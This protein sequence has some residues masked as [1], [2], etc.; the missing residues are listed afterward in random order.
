MLEFRNFFLASEFGK[1]SSF[2]VRDYLTWVNFINCTV[3]KG[4]TLGQAY[5]HGAFV[6]FLDTLGT[7]VTS[8][9]V[10]ECH[11]FR[12]KCFKFLRA[13]MIGVKLVTKAEFR[14]TPEIERSGGRFGT[15]GFSIESKSVSE[16]AD[17][18]GN[19]LFSFKTP[20]THSNLIKILRAMQL[21]KA[22]LLEGSPGVGKTAL[23]QALAQATG[24]SLTRINLSEQTDVC[25]LFGTDLPVDGGDGGTFE[26]KDGP[27]LK[28]LKD[29]HWILLDELNLASQSVLEGLN[30]VLDHRGELFIPEIGRSFLVKPGTRLFATQNPLSQ[31]S[32]RKGLPKSFLNRFTQVYISSFTS[33]DIKLIL[34]HIFQDLVIGNKTFATKIFDK[35]LLFNERL[36]AKCGVEFG[37][38]GSPWEMNLRDLVR[39]VEAM[40]RFNSNN[41]GDF[42]GVIYVDRMRTSEDKRQ[43]EALYKE[44]FPEK[45]FA[46][47]KGPFTLYPTSEEIYFGDIRLPKASSGVNLECESALNLVLRSDFNALRSLAVTT[48][49]QWM[50]ILVG[51]EH[52]KHLINTFAQLSGRKLHIVS[53]SSD[54]DTMEIL[55]GY[56]QIDLNRHLSEIGSQV[57][58]LLLHVL[59][60]QGGDNR[61]DTMQLVEQYNALSNQVVPLEERKDTKVFLDKIDRLS[62]L[63]IP[64]SSS[65]IAEDLLSQLNSF[66]SRVLALSQSG[67]IGSGG[68]EWVDSVLVKALRQGSWLLMDN[69]NM[70]SAAVL[71]RLNGLLEPSGVLTLHERGVSSSGELYTIVPHP[72]F[73]LFLCMDP[74]YG[75][76]SRAMR[77][78]GVEIALP[79]EQSS[80]LSAS[81]S[82]MGSNLDL[83]EL[84]AVQGVPQFD[85][86]CLLAHIHVT[87]SD[88]CVLSNE[89]SYLIRAA[90]LF[91][92]YR[93]QKFTVKAALHIACREIYVK[94]HMWCP[95]QYKILGDLLTSILDKEIMGDVHRVTHSNQPPSIT[96]TNEQAVS[97]LS[98]VMNQT[99]ELVSSVASVDICPVLPILSRDYLY[100]STFTRIRHQSWLLY[101]YVNAYMRHNCA[102][103]IVTRSLLPIPCEELYEGIL[104]DELTFEEAFPYLVM[105]AYEYASVGDMAFRRQ[106][107]LRIVEEIKCFSA[108]QRRE[109]AKRISNSLDNWDTRLDETCNNNVRISPGPLS[110]KKKKSKRRTSAYCDSSVVGNNNLPQSK[111]IC[112]ISEAFDRVNCDSTVCDP[113]DC[114]RLD[115]LSDRLRVIVDTV[116]NVAEGQ[117]EF[118]LQGEI[119]RPIDV[120]RTELIPNTNEGVLNKAM[121]LKM[122]FTNKYVAACQSSVA[123]SNRVQ[124]KPFTVAAYSELFEKDDLPFTLDSPILSHF[125]TIRARMDQLV[126]SIL[127]TPSSQFTGQDLVPVYLALILRDRFESIGSER[128]GPEQS[129]NHIEQVLAT[130]HLHFQ[131]FNKLFH[132]MTERFYW[133]DGSPE[134]KLH[135]SRLV[136]FGKFSSTLLR[137]HNR[138]YQKHLVLA[139]KKFHTLLPMPLPPG[140]NSVARLSAI[141]RRAWDLVDVWNHGLTE[142]EIAS[143]ITLLTSEPGRQLKAELLASLSLLTQDHPPSDV[144]TDTISNKIENLLRR[145]AQLKDSSTTAEESSMQVDC[146]SSDGKTDGVECPKDVPAEIVLENG[147]VEAETASNF[148]SRTKLVPFY[149]YLALR[150]NENVTSFARKEI[151]LNRRTHVP[152][153]GFEDLRLLSVLLR[154]SPATPPFVIESLRGGAYMQLLTGL[155]EMKLYNAALFRPQAW[156]HGE[157]IVKEDEEEDVEMMDVTASAAAEKMKEK[158][159]DLILSPE[160][161]LLSHLLTTVLLKPHTH[162]FTHSSLGS[163]SERSDLL[164]RIKAI[165]WRNMPTIARL[166]NAAQS[167]LLAGLKSQYEALVGFLSQLVSGV[168]QPQILT[169]HLGL[170]RDYLY[171]SSPSERNEARGEIQLLLGH[172]Q[173]VILSKMELID[174]VEKN[175]LKLR[176]VRHVIRDIQRIV[177]LECQHA[178][179][180]GSGTRFP[181]AEVYVRT[182]ST[183]EDKEDTCMKRVGVRPEQSALMYSNLLKE[184]NSFCRSVSS[185][186]RIRDIIRCRKLC[187]LHAKQ[188]SAGHFKAEM[189][190]TTSDVKAELTLWQYSVMSFLGKLRT[191]YGAWYP[192]VVVP[193]AYAITQMVTGVNTILVELQRNLCRVQLDIPSSP[194]LGLLVRFP[195]VDKAE[196][197]EFIGVV[198]SATFVKSFEQCFDH[199]SER[200]DAVMRLVKCSLEELQNIIAI[201]NTGTNGSGWCQLKGRTWDTMKTILGQLVTSWHSKTER[202]TAAKIEEESLYLHKTR[203]LCP[204]EQ[205]DE[206]LER[207][208]NEMFPTNREEFSE[209]EQ[210]AGLESNLTHRHMV[211][212]LEKNLTEERMLETCALHSN[213]VRTY[214]SAH[215]LKAGVGGANFFDP[216]SP[217][218]ER[219][220]V[221]SVLLGAQL[222]GLESSLDNDVLGSLVFMSEVA[223][224]YRTHAKNKEY[225]FYRDPNV[226][227]IQTCLPILRGL[228]AKVST[229]LAEWPDHPTLQSIHLLVQRVLSFDVTSPVTRFLTGLEILMGKVHEWEEVAHSGV[230][231]ATHSE[232]LTN[233]IIAWR[234]LE[235]SLWKNCL[236]V[237]SRRVTQD[238]SRYWFHLYAVCDNY[239]RD[240]SLARDSVR[241]TLAN[242]VE[243]CCL[244]VFVSRLDLLLTFHCHVLEASRVNERARDLAYILWNLYRYY[245]QFIPSV[246]AKIQELSAPL[247]KQ[248]KDFVKI[249]RWNDI[250]YYAVKQTTEKTHRT[251]AKHVKEF[252]R[253]LKSHVSAGMIDLTEENKKVLP[254]KDYSL[255]ESTFT[256]TVQLDLLIQL[257]T[258]PDGKLYP[259]VA[260]KLHTRSG[261]LCQHIMKGNNYNMLIGAVNEFVINILENLEHARNMSVD[262]NQVK[263]K[264]K[265]QAKQFL[266]FKRKCLVDLFS[267]LTKSG[268]SYRFGTVSKT[269]TLKEISSKYFTTPPVNVKIAVEQ[270]DRKA[271]DAELIASWTG[272]DKHLLKSQARLSQLL[273]LV[274]KPHKQ[275]SPQTVPRLKGFASH[276]MSLNVDQNSHLVDC[277][278]TFY[279]LRCCLT[280]LPEISTK[281]KLL[282]PFKT[283]ATEL[284]SDIYYYYKQFDMFLSVCPSCESKTGLLNAKCNT[285]ISACKHDAKYNEV[286]EKIDN[287]LKRVAELTTRLNRVETTSDLLEQLLVTMGV[288][289]S[290]CSL[291]VSNELCF[292]LDEVYTVLNSLLDDIQFI[293]KQF[294]LIPKLLPSHLSYREPYVQYSLTNGLWKVEQKIIMSCDKYFALNLTSTMFCEPKQVTLDSTTLSN[295]FFKTFEKKV[296]EFLQRIMIPIQELYKKY[297]DNIEN[298]DVSPIA[299]KSVHE[300]ISKNHLKEKLLEDLARDVNALNMKSVLLELLDMLSSCMSSPGHLL[301]ACVRTVQQVIPLLDQ[302]C[303]LCEYFLTHEAASL[304][305]SAKLCSILCATFCDLAKRGFCVSDELISD[306]NEG[307][308]QDMQ[309]GMGLGDDEGMNDVS[310]QIENQDQME[311]CKPEGSKEKEEEKDCKEEDNGVE[312]SDDFSGKL[313]DIE[314]N[315]EE[316]DDEEKEDENKDKEEDPDNEMGETDDKAEKLDEEVWGSD[317]EEEPEEENDKTEDDADKGKQTGEKELGAKDN[318]KNETEGDD[319][320]EYKDDNKKEI[321][322]MDDEGEEDQDQVDPFHGNQE[323]LPEPEPFDLP[324]NLNLDGEEKDENEEGNDEENPLEVDQMK[325][326][327]TVEDEEGDDGKDENKENEQTVDSSD[328]EDKT[329]ENEGEKGEDIEKEEAGEEE[330]EN[331]GAEDG[332]KKDENKTG[333]E[334]K[335]EEKAGDLE[336]E[337]AQASEDRPTLAEAESA[338]NKD[339]G[340]KDEVKDTSESDSKPMDPQESNTEEATGPEQ[341]GVGMTDKTESKKSK[342]HEGDKDQSRASKEEDKE[343]NEKKRQKPGESNEERTL[344]D[345]EEPMKKRLKTKNSDKENRMEPEEE[346]AG[347]DKKAELYEH[348]KESKEKDKPKREQTL[349]AATNEQAEKQTVQEEN[350][351]DKEEE[352]N[353]GAE[354]LTEEQDED[355]AEDKDVPTQ[356]SEKLDKKNKK[357]KNKKDETSNEPDEAMDTGQPIEI[358]GEVIATQNVDR[359]TDT[360][361]HTLATEYQAIDLTNLNSLDPAELRL[362]LQRQLASWIQPPATAEASRAWDLFSAA[363]TPLAQQ[364]SQELRLVLEP[365]RASSLRGDFRT[366]RR[367]N[368]RKVIPYIASKFRKDKIWLRRT[369]PQKRDY[370]IVLAIDDSSSMADNQSRELAFE[371]LALVSKALTL[372]ETGELSIVSFGETTKV[373]HH[374][375][376]QFSESSGASILQQFKFDQTK[377][378]VANLVEEMCKVF[379][380]RGSTNTGSS[381]A[382]L[383]VIISDGRNINSEGASTVKSAVKLAKSLNVFIV[384]LIIDNPKSKS[385]ILDIRMPVFNASSKVVALNSYLDTFPFPFY[386][387]LRDINSLPSVLSDALRQWFELVTS[388][389]R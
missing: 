143:R 80:S 59:S 345:V 323:P 160:H 382:Q 19:D 64:L 334:R 357:N 126:E 307:E 54:M 235:L 89:V 274:K 258:S 138:H 187:A 26:W 321:N 81:P 194:S 286:K 56:E 152:N 105:I 175:K 351:E 230:S 50:T 16:D 266:Q 106:Y 182:L 66:R 44:V 166:N 360:T 265:S 369:K 249:A 327:D 214:T 281:T 42:V 388:S 46:M 130:L 248:V 145:V 378:R 292:A 252:E 48:G 98:S 32:S 79:A 263:E 169:H 223:L 297:M 76:I 239:V 97:L 329:E 240:V 218:V 196:C 184:V 299:D 36:N 153:F 363:V 216:V 188:A 178:C 209:F 318:N 90:N 204:T 141:V 340:S 385:S 342:G 39:W 43:V 275:I 181:N 167:Q 247:Q 289:S 315:P 310:D 3:L 324:D 84:L 280:L 356:Q 17:L 191:E 317:S 207:Y 92:A 219:F 253:V 45:Q 51:G 150:L 185:D 28:A 271:S 276:L 131:W 25:D 33:D 233:Q 309:G 367:I 116:H 268:L 69:V 142:E 373:L 87:L 262:P 168:G 95:S 333:E 312:M 40:Q 330:E 71:D 205:E 244:G 221:F 243:N 320:E 279:A 136:S 6:T 49:M 21:P 170:I 364:L 306:E 362:A 82:S 119:N 41:P 368:M 354:E 94:P 74:R 96:S 15:W 13:Q 343:N 77:N 151:L 78:R 60:T 212:T 86:Q 358:E 228:D 226:E 259:L 208:V 62:S 301:T 383:L 256:S 103:I 197:L 353:E 319:K 139:R 58:R 192:D 159:K 147:S 1:R 328:E 177:T 371:S 91:A 68:F 337:Q 308:G 163:H 133:S 30:A 350:E 85:V 314:E 282:K 140:E 217:F 370:Q 2:S 113:V 146:R 55:G 264:Q 10:S 14:K 206:E 189:I 389:S 108:K 231:L 215:W 284:L 291:L 352:M 155:A 311:D 157:E 52:S 112:D 365:T 375:G 295:A 288:E 20:T 37:Y 232:E 201:S 316:G 11:A 270:L 246:N 107:L 381:V 104:L 117:V 355:Q 296:D 376:D 127:L 332:G 18:T 29:E 338:D 27:F 171:H 260:T 93:Q 374:L 322:E 124:G 273:T 211:K 75:E 53:V 111:A 267:L 199:E 210:P 149:E 101:C 148:S 156:I 186:G 257:D 335:E 250:N 164:T 300:L 236:G 198:N 8:S 172:S 213:I 115:Q 361:F 241:A 123:V 227:Q 287:I 73:R 70:C 9:L 255:A 7:G 203:T 313:Q 379:V 224:Q 387:I 72:E 278:H 285:V 220:S 154:E 183:L 261:K 222:P 134:A 34:K 237:T 190:R 161:P 272:W 31:G 294:D 290:Y 135:R 176:H 109:H 359:G 277:I 339:K 336:E 24:H 195:F 200:A 242:F 325:E 4:L 331:E 254:V 165:L 12:R 132:T 144:T 57:E 173:L 120:R 162:Q 347:D 118:M 346:E 341:K 83:R 303:L 180:T 349:D 38:Y 269:C 326:P 384:F 193:L 179:V 99:S 102:P 47:K 22:I 372:L 386:L 23:L 128:V 344:G 174:P 114:D 88:Q 100:D 298:V 67:K 65:H 305:A 348:I 380:A 129:P 366:G 35:M 63:L 377:T 61:V 245:S 158:N 293:K 251:L 121:L 238:T 229:L 225:D 234:R 110:S 302:Y 202:E 122:Y 125:N 5:V 137:S 283:S 304:R